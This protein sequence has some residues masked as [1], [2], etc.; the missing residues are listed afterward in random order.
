MKPDISIIITNYNYSRYLPQCLESCLG[1]LTRYTLEVI[2]VD[3][4]S[5]DSS[6][7]LVKSYNDDRI[8]LLEITNSGIEVASNMGIA[9]SRSDFIV[10][11]DADD[12]LMPNYIDSL[13]PAM[14]DKRISFAYADYRVVDEQG[15]TL[16]EVTLPD[17]DREEIVKRGDFLAT[18]TICRKSV[19]DAMGGYDPAIR[20]CGLENYC[21]I[22]KMLK[23]SHAGIHIRQSLFAYRRHCKN[24]SIHRREAIIEYGISMF[25]NFGMGSYRT[26]T[27]HPYGLVIK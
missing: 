14:Y 16:S 26:N 22:L 25:N 18:G 15:V 24:M 6:V 10:R 7:E 20:N 8:Q 2:V 4:E 9:N 27:Y 5:T 11:V 12:Y 19:F 13:L 17:F 23:A 21:L 3:D 1:Q